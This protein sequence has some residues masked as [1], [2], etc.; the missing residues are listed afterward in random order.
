MS[1]ELQ[2]ET[3]DWEQLA[4]SFMDKFQFSNDD[5]TIDVAFQVIKT[6]IFEDIYVSMTSFHQSS[7]I[8]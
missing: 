3:I 4:S 5:L 1:V 7:A 8:V 2:R 6:K